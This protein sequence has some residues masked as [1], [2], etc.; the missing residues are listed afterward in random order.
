MTF[1]QICPIY[2]GVKSADLL[3]RLRRLAAQRGWRIEIMEGG[4]HTKVRLNGRGTVVPRHAKDLKSGTFRA[5]L[6]QLGLSECD[7][8]T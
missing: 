5:I 3:R 7:L 2:P 8:E 6:R 1:G 4:A